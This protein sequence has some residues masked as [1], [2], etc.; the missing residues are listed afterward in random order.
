MAELSTLLARI[1]REPFADLPIGD[2]V[3]QVLAESG[4]VWRERLLPPLVTLRLFVVQILS[5]NCA[6]AALRQLS[7]I[8][9]A[10]ASYCEARRR[11]P[12]PLLQS[13]LQW[14]NALASQSLVAVKTLGAARPDR[15]W[16]GLFDARHPRAGQAL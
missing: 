8:D 16:L 9:F 6:I 1:R 13:L 2:H 10:P 14:M 4:Y 5:G 3:H 15:R 11:M 12:L 7:G